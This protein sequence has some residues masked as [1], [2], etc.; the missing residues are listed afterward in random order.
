[1]QHRVYFCPVQNLTTPL[2]IRRSSYIRSNRRLVPNFNS[3]K[4]RWLHSRGF[5]GHGVQM[6]VFCL[7]SFR[8]LQKL[9]DQPDITR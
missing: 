7:F 2:D 5:I 9:L 4:L 3:G 8:L 6:L 1:M